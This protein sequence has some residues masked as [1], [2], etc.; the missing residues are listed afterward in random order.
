MREPLPPDLFEELCPSSL[1][2]IRFGDKWAG[3]ILTCLRTGPRRYSELRVPLARVTPKVLTR[4]LRALER[5]GLL[6]RTVS[7]CPPRVEYELTPLGHSLMELYATVCD[8]T[9]RH[10]DELLE[11]RE[12]YDATHA[13]AAAR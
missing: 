3:L 7:Q 6:T 5:D 10:W 8:W 13:E 11:A 4:S 1:V 9:A 2:P 12:T